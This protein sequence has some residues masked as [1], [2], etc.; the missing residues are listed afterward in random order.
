[1]GGGGGILPAIQFAECPHQDNIKSYFYQDMSVSVV[2]DLHDNHR[3]LLKYCGYQ[4]QSY[5]AILKREKSQNNAYS[6]AV[7]IFCMGEW[8][9]KFLIEDGVPE[10]KVYA[11]G[12]GINLDKKRIDTSKKVGNKILFVGRDF[13]RKN[14][15]LV[16]EAFKKARAIKNDLEL[17]IAGPQPGE[18]IQGV[19]WLGDVPSEK[20][21][22]YF[23]LCD[24]FCMPSKFEAY[25]IV[26]IEAL[27]YGLPCIGRNAFEMPYLIQDGETGYILKEESPNVL[28]DLML[29]LLSNE[30][31]K[32][33]VEKNRENYIAEYSWDAVAKRMYNVISKDIAKGN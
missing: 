4:N 5:K 13:V 2:R 3:E 11:V 1:M 31:I 15:P 32:S 8:F 9:R 18:S 17:Y 10:D 12:A 25:G 7:G 24:I 22:D 20:L 14:G 23:N 21:S 16:V 33:N 27:T 29:K 28:A 30:N 26:F 6:D 19:Y